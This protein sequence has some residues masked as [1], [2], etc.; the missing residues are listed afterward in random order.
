MTLGHNI[1]HRDFQFNTEE[2]EVSFRD[3]FNSITSA[4]YGDYTFRLELAGHTHPPVDRY[5]VTAATPLSAKP[6]SRPVP[7][8]SGDPEHILLASYVNSPTH[9]F[10][11][12]IPPRLP[13]VLFFFVPSSCRPSSPQ[14]SSS[15]PTS[16]VP[17]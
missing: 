14:P 3:I 9:P 15:L 6:S 7:D 1:V 16:P 12:N 11:F 4:F 8:H 10:S 13:H 5:V 2:S 17:R